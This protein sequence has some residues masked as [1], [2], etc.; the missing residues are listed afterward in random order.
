MSTENP[1]AGAEGQP[2]EKSIAEQIIEARGLA[3]PS[4][5]FSQVRSGNRREILAQNKEAR[6]LYDSVVSIINTE[7]Y[8]MV[9]SNTND[10]MD[11]I[12]ILAEEKGWKNYDVNFDDIRKELAVMGI[13]LRARLMKE[14]L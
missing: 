3:G 2:S 5:D 11:A 6:E 1:F 4:L 14:D 9:G 10:V 7:E 8:P 12:G 13:P